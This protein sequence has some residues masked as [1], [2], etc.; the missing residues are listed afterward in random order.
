MPCLKRWRIV[1]NAMDEI[2]EMLDSVSKNT[3]GKRLFGVGP[4]D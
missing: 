4:G 1:A 3:A 2:V